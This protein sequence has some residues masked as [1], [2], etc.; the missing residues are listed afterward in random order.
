MNIQLTQCL[1]NKKTDY[2]LPFFWQQGQSHERLLEEII[3]IKKSGAN[4]FCVES[5]THEKFCEDQWWDDFGFMLK[6]AREMDMK[7][8]LLDDKHFPT[9]YALGVIK[10]KYP[11]LR[12]K[13][14]RREVVDVLGPQKDCALLTNFYTQDGDRIL[15]AVAYKRSGD[16]IDCEGEGIDIT[17]TY[18]DDMVF[19]DIPEGMWRVFFIIETD[20]FQTTQP[21]HIDKLN[22][23]SCNLMIS[24]IYQPHYDRF[25]EYFGNTFVGFFSDEP[26]FS[27]DTGSYFSTVGKNIL[28]P[29]SKEIIGV[30]AEELKLSD[31]EVWALMPALWANVGK[32]TAKTRI[33]YMNTITKLYQKYFSGMLANWCREK[34]VMYIGH[35]IE[36]MNACMHTGN[37]SGH[38]FRALDPQSMAGIDVVLQ[39]VMPGQNG[40]LH[41][42]RIYDRIADPTF[43]VYALAKLAASHS[44]INPAMKNRAMCEIYGAYG[45]AEGLPFMKKLSDHFLANGIN[46]FVPHAF[47][48]QYP[49]TDCPPHFY[50]EGNNPQFELFGELMRYMQRVIHL[51]EGSVHKANALV[52]FNADCDW[53]G[54]DTSLYFHVAKQ[55]TTSNI[56]FDF[57]PIDYL[58]RL[59]VTDGKLKLNQ[60]SYDLLIVPG[61]D[62]I[63]DEFEAWVKILSDAGAKIIFTDRHPKRTA[64][65]LPATACCSC[66]S[67]PENMLGSRLREMG[68]FDLSV[69]GNGTYLRH[70]H[71]VSGNDHLIMFKNDSEEK[72]DVNI[73]LPVQGKLSVYD[74]WK[75]KLYLKSSTRLCLA[76]GESTIWIIGDTDA[77]EEFPET[78]DLQRIAADLLWDISIMEV[79][80]DKAT[81]Y[82]SQSPLYNLSRRGELTHFTGKIF[83]S[84]TLEINNADEIKFID[85]GYVGETAKLTVNGKDAGTLIVEPYLFDIR[86]LLNNGKNTVEVEV[87]NSPVFKERDVFSR[88]MKILPSGILGPVELLK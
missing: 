33:A 57:V 85:L 37:S 23:E 78:A 53:S 58:D 32:N 9:G 49:S 24:E 18:E 87:V 17:S 36:D 22:P 81:A 60:E 52:Y 26:G 30:M 42:A 48:P 6:T 5:R 80:A 55:L 34:G 19:F 70:Y 88:Y 3:A 1:E 56:D 41:T 39:Q 64:N 61:C 62:C 13:Y 7:V 84:T 83:Y 79:G 21:Y 46:R 15:R 74:A 54:E 20:R 25:K 43:F 16:G 28:L 59:T 31:N 29:W 14:F 73:I 40:M 38:F 10:E 2:I 65:D 67:V 35:I 4:S 86:G 50:C 45:F 8:W 47:T 72:L 77:T 71:T 44:H 82:K 68:F 51:F 69:E 66:E 75:N 11:H 27:N 63:S 12:K 76:P